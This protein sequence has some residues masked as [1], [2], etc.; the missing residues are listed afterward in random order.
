MKIPFRIFGAGAETIA[1]TAANA[2]N[3]LSDAAETAA[4]IATAPLRKFGDV[5]L[6]TGQVA[7]SGNPVPTNRF[8]LTS[9]EW[10]RYT[11]NRDIMTARRIWATDSYASEVINNI[12]DFAAG[13][14]AKVIFDDEKWQA[15]WNSWAWNRSNVL[16]RPPELFQIA[17]LRLIR[18][19][20]M[21]D[22]KQVAPDG[23][24][25]LK[26]LNPGY[27]YGSPGIGLG[28]SG[29]TVDATGKPLSYLYRP[30]RSYVGQE[31]G[32]QYRADQIIHVFKTEW[33]EPQLIGETWLRKALKALDELDNL[34][35]S[36]VFSVVRAA[37]TPALW[38][39]PLHYAFAF[40]RQ[41]DQEGNPINEDEDADQQA[42]ASQKILERTM[43]APGE[44][45]IVP[46][47]VELVPRPFQ[48]TVSDPARLVLLERIC[49]GV[50]ISMAAAL[51]K[52]GTGGY[53]SNRF[54]V[55]QDEKFYSRAQG[56]G[57]R[58]LREVIDWWQSVMANTDLELTRAPR[59]YKIELP[60]FPMANLQ[61]DVMAMK[62]L[63][64]MEV[65]SPQTVSRRYGYD[66]YQEL[67]EMQEWKR[68]TAPAETEESE[69]VENDN[70]GSPSGQ[71][72]AGR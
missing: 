41:V 23:M 5:V 35:A 6:R 52:F 26:M 12:V 71:P 68:L 39:I 55:A 67:A 46:D 42:L 62:G 31:R 43:A 16:D 2:V 45:G 28:Y 8:R 61:Q 72:Q 64:E 4:S 49:R 24:P 60:V 66:P 57:D 7:P 58:Y 51:G 15:K 29:I 53:L 37:K 38:K 18:D 50:G 32:C 54:A 70:G 36:M 59:A 34:D 17:I 48:A 3:T 30:Q 25:Y 63:R 19:G 22:A 27:L 56:L 33:D 11:P 40:V 21:L 44:D 13:D 47:D 9:G 65:V 69:E 14:G 1:R 20:N 10:A